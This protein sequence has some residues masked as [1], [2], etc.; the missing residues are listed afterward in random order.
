[1][2]TIHCLKL[3]LPKHRLNTKNQS[4]SDSS[5]LSMQ[6]YECW[7]CTFSPNLEKFVLSKI[8]KW[9]QIRRIFL[10][11]RQK[12]KSVFDLKWKQSGNGCD[13]K[14]VVTVSLPMVPEISFFR[15]CC[16]KHKKHGKRELGFFKAEFRCT[17]TLCLCSKTYCCYDVASKQVKF[18]GKVLD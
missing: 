8:W 17:K 4:L 7:T 11:L 12:L 1:M 6:N 16:D 5:F 10:L 3:N 15:M 13:Q 18:S 14:S 2:S 9:I